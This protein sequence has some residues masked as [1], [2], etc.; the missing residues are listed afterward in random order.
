CDHFQVQLFPKPIPHT[1]Q[2]LVLALSAR[3]NRYIAWSSTRPTVEF[4]SGAPENRR[5]FSLTK[6]IIGNE[7]RNTG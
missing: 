7:S 6:V 3:I 4:I 1:G 2:A 5:P